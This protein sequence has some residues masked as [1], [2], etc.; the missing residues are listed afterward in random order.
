MSW[1]DE[2]VQKLKEL[3][4]KGHT[5]SQI[6]EA[7]GDTTR[8]AVIGKAH[9]LNLEARAPSKYNANITK[10]EG[11]ISKKNPKT[12]SLKSKFKS[13]MLDKNFEAENPTSLENLTDKTCRWPIGHPDEDNFYFC[14]RTPEAEFPYCKL[15]IL[16]AFQPKGQKDDVLDKDDEIP[17]FIE[18]KVKSSA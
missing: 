12:V 4:K 5:A 10:Q 13:I 17:E 2:K 7:F 9:S 11:K 8:T 3:W 14:G 1:T 16:Y 18:K 6:A 15:H